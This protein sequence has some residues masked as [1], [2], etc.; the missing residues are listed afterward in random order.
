MV[1]RRFSNIIGGWNRE[2]ELKVRGPEWM[3]PVLFGVGRAAM[4]LAG[5]LRHPSS[6]SIIKANIRRRSLA[7]WTDG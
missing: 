5:F 2:M 3:D 6:T 7:L 1:E 4:S